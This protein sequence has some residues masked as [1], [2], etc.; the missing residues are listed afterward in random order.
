MPCPSFNESWSKKATSVFARMDCSDWGVGRWLAS[1]HAIPCATCV[2]GDEGGLVSLRRLFVLMIFVFLPSNRIYT[3]GRAA[4]QLH[5]LFFFLSAAAT[6][7]RPSIW[8]D[9]GCGHGECLCVPRG[10]TV[11]RGGENR[12]CCAFVWELYS[13]FPLHR[14]VLHRFCGE[15]DRRPCFWTSR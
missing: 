4:A 3:P 10:P 1:I 12:D 8:L 2:T 7:T 14:A 15:C 13:R 5:R 6:P 9:D 11:D